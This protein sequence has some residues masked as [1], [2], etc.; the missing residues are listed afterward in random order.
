MNFEQIVSSSISD[1]QMLMDSLSSSLAVG[2]I[3]DQYF[4]VLSRGY[5][6]I[7]WDYVISKHDPN[8]SFDF[9]FKLK[10]VGCH[11][12]V[13]L[14][15][16]LSSFIP[17]DETLEIYGIEHFDND[18]V[19]KGIEHFDNDSVLKG[20]MFLYSLFACLI[21]MK[22]LD[23]KY[24]K[25]VDVEEGNN[26]LRG[27]YRQFGFIEDGCQDLMISLDVLEEHLRTKE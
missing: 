8:D 26:A 23:G 7:N 6:R 5:G 16:F 10:D 17:K 22:K 14:G 25:L 3:S 9:G 24:I 12:G 27:Y 13:L 2:P 15:A 1:F 18:S 20:K 21:F 4:I 19:L 11:S